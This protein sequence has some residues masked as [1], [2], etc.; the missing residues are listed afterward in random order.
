MGAV[1]TGQATVAITLGLT[2]QSPI[3]ELNPPITVTTDPASPI[4]SQSDIRVMTDSAGHVV[5]VPSI[6]TSADIRVT[7]DSKG[8]VVSVLMGYYYHPS[9]TTN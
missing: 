7:T 1:S 9:I 2:T 4:I 6:A 3:T 5:V 8:Y